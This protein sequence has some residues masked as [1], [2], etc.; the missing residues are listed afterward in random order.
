ME[1]PMA[2]TRTPD[3]HEQRVSEQIAKLEQRHRALVEETASELEA[4]KKQITE[5]HDVRERVEEAQKP[6]LSEIATLRTNIERAEKE[7]LQLTTELER[8]HRDYQGHYSQ[9]QG[10]LGSLKH[11]VQNQAQALDQQVKLLSVDTDQAID[12]LLSSLTEATPAQTITPVTEKVEPLP[13][14][15]DDNLEALLAEFSPVAFVPEE[16]EVTVQAVAEEKPRK[17]KKQRSF[18]GLRRLAIRTVGLALVVALGWGGLKTIQSKNLAEAG[19]VAGVSTDKSVTG[20][21]DSQNPAE[22]Y[23]QSYAI[24]PFDQTEWTSYTDPDFGVSLRW[25]QNASNVLK[26][27][28]GS[29]I[30]FL[31]FD[32][33][34]MRITLDAT[35]DTL[36]SWWQKNSGFY[37][38]DGSATKGTFK[39]HQAWIVTPTTATGNVGTTYIFQTPKG[40]MQVWTKSFDPATDDG[41]RLAKMVDSFSFA[42]N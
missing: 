39:N 27:P 1:V 36:E 41:K 15:T 40:I 28:G 8:L 42:A 31:R 21:G 33:Y 24:V 4:L 16:P 37:T 7:K 23:K 19:Q 2:T 17:E 13:T 6:L 18:T 3:E 26:T 14:V 11:V 20:S 29:N 25:P 12:E 22:E 30:W 10:A 35:T 9:L 32:A 5:G 38:S 34:Y